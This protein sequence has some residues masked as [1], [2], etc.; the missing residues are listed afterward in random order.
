MAAD[1]DLGPI[2][3]IKI[4]GGRAADRP[5]VLGHHAPPPHH[6]P[7]GGLFSKLFA[8]IIVIAAVGF[9]VAPW[10]ALQAVRS[11]AEARDAQALNEL[12]DFNAV[13]DGL[14]AQLSGAPAP[15]PV[16]PWKHPIEAM[17][18]A[19]HPLPA[20]AGPSVE[21]YLTP[22]ALNAL[23]NGRPVGQPITERPWPILRYWGFDRCRMA[24]RDPSDGRR[25]TLL[26]FQRRGWYDWK[27]S[28]V[29]LPGK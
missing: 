25:E 11:A 10:F 6:K 12:V 17:R 3:G 14:K 28:Q 23:T 5:A 20:I 22:D 9:F 7:K 29:L 21:T 1:D 27:L 24:V 16:D 2:G 13:R 15:A 26:T 4:G 18:Q 19:L 8:A